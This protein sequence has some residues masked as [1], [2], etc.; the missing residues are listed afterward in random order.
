MIYDNPNP[1]TVLPTQP[2]PSSSSKPTVMGPKYMHVNHYQ[3]CH[4]RMCK[5]PV[6]Y[7]PYSH[8]KQGNHENED[9]SARHLTTEFD[10]SKPQYFIPKPYSPNL[11]PSIKSKW[12]TAKFPYWT[13]LTTISLFLAWHPQWKIWRTI[14][15]YLTFWRTKMN[16]IFYSDQLI[17]FSSYF[18]WTKN[19]FDPN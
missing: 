3:S 6:I 16:E 14:S 1:A 12:R 18:T 10:H 7:R 13:T 4:A 2:P 15:T 5:S 8:S 19:I 17:L 11:K 9:S